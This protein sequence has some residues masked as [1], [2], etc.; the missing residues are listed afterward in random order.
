MN[1][2]ICVFLVTSLITAPCFSMSVP[3]K[4]AEQQRVPIHGGG[5]NWWNDKWNFP[6]LKTWGVVL[7]CGVISGY[8][9]ARNDYE[10][11]TATW[12]W[13][14]PYMVAGLYTACWIGF[15]GWLSPCFDDDQEASST[16][17]A[18]EQGL[19]IIDY[20]NLD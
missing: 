2:I 20:E 9:Y 8:I 13:A 10:H 16:H 7:V 6:G 1:R 19:D 11:S 3:S 5:A 18:I 12:L 14:A 17:H 4:P 15:F